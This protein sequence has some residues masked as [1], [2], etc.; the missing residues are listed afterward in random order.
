MADTGNQLE[1]IPPPEPDPRPLLVFPA[2][3]VRPRETGSPRPVP[4]PQ[5]PGPRRQ[6]ERLTSKFAAL[7]SALSAD[8]TV[9]SSTTPA[10]DLELMVVFEVAGTIRNF[11]AAAGRIVGLEFIVE[12]VGQEFEP[13]DDFR[14]LDTDGDPTDK[15][16]TQ[17]LYLVMSTRRAADEIVH[18]FDRSKSYPDEDFPPG[19]APLKNL[20]SQ[21]RD[22]RLWGPQD[23]IADTGM[24]KRLQDDIEVKGASGTIRVEIEL[25]WRSSESRRSRAQHAIEQIL[26]EGAV[27]DLVVLPSICY[28]AILAEIPA[29]SLQPIL[30]DMP[31]EI[32]LLRAEDVLF[33]SPSSAMSF[34]TE[35]GD[36]RAVPNLDWSLPAGDPKV[37]LLDGYPLENHDF[38]TGR[39]FVDDP[40]NLGSSYPTSRRVHGTEMA[41]LVIHGDLSDPG[42][43]LQS[44]LFIRPVMV[45]QEGLSSG[46][47]LQPDRLFVD[48]MHEAFQSLFGDPEPTAPSVRI[49][50]VSIGDSARPFIRRI[51]PLARLLDYMA[52]RYDLLIIVSGGNQDE[53]SPIVAT[54]VL[55]DPAILTRAVRTSLHEQRLLRRLFSPAEAIN[56]LT[57][58]ALH[59]DAASTSE[60][61]DTVVD[62]LPQGSIATYSPVGPGLG[63]CPKPEI[64]APGGRMLYEKPVAGPAPAKLKPAR[65]PATGPGLLVAAPTPAGG[66]A[67][68]LYTVGTSAAAALTTRSA[69]AVLKAL[70][71]LAIVEGHP[72]PPG[73]QYH[74][75][76]VKALLVHATMWPNGAEE[77]AAELGFAGR[78]KKRDLTEY[79]GFGALD[80]DRLANAAT[81]RVTLIGSGSITG[82]QSQKFRF[83]LPPSLSTSREWRR[84]LV[85][86]AWLSPT[87]A[88][89]QRYR[90]ARLK[91]NASRDELCLSPASQSIYRYMNGAGTIIHEVL[92]GKA[93]TAYVVGDELAIDVECRVQVGQLHQPVRFGLAATLELGSSLRI[94]IHREVSERLRERVQVRV[95]DNTSF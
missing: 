83:P 46:E 41:S 1:L 21:L 65:L 95:R 94:D 90:V 40:Y 48:V 69:H 18:L 50:N 35:L 61:P 47:C 70:E 59:Q 38:L 62:P 39:L 87:E 26:T 66:T 80:A 22:V 79:L 77:W 17:T 15:S 27:L 74:A 55:N 34:T 93:A 88:M 78:R 57:A 73:V 13:D 28:H 89:T 29:N 7:V 64:H 36:V 82:D 51:S 5:G 53:I 16:V 11:I 44:P 14:Y 67:G 68:T 76:L 91:C 32:A 30:D 10:S 63:R 85:T 12:F 31:E 43:C 2:A 23:R 56:V 75:V 33:V 71:S 42:P 60:T 54:E 92:E 81:N 49:V 84:F 3:E 8:T 20:F 45:P 19:L 72:E 58:G 86:L 6:G 24:K 4:S 52:H 9:L 25:V 37:A